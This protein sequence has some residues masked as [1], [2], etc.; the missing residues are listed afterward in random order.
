MKLPGA[1]WL[2]FLIEPCGGI[3]RF[4]HTVIYEPKGFTGQLYWFL[5]GPAHALIFNAMHKAMLKE[6]A[7]ISALDEHE[8]HLQPA[9]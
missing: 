8:L 9:H 2:E 3:T 1:G 4:H 7:L 6:A 5:T